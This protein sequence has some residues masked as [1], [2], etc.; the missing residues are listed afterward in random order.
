MRPRLR[1]C[2]RL[3]ERQTVLSSIHDAGASLPVRFEFA[4]TDTFRSVMTRGGCKVLHYSGHGATKFIGM[5]D[6]RGGMHRVRITSHPNHF[7]GAFLDRQLI[8][9]AASLPLLLT[10]MRATHA[11]CNSK[12]AHKT[13]QQQSYNWSLPPSC[14]LGS[15]DW[16][17]KS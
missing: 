16:Q 1:H 5:E 2:W 17:L 3:G 6:G 10:V 13:T 12:S 8:Q 11:S 7:L 9:Q 4:T 15:F 14:Q